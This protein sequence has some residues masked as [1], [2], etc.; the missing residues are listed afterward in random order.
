[1]TSQ[2]S[3]VVLAAMILA[4]VAGPNSAAAQTVS[5]GKTFAVVGSV[6]AICVGGS[7]AEAG[8]VFDL[9]VLV[10]TSTGLLR[11]D[12]SVPAQLLSGSFC[13]SR[14]SIA[15]AA[16]PIEAQTFTSSAPAGF[17]RSVDFTAIASGWTATPASFATAASANPGALQQ[18]D[19]PFTGPISVSIGNFATSGGAALRLVADTSYRGTVT[20]T[21]TPES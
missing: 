14:S 20:V 13:S 8:G 12:L 5:D 4:W 7:V 16:T 1:M 21:L 2:R 11:D 3:S 18:R 6:P 9:G 15:V 10:N 19:T 17:S